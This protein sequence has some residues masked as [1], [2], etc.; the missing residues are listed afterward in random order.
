MAPPAAAQSPALCEQHK[1]HHT[2]QSL[3]SLTNLRRHWLEEPLRVFTITVPMTFLIRPGE[4]PA[5][6]VGSVLAYW[7]ILIHANVR[8]PLG[9]LAPVFCGPQ[10]HRTTTRASRRTGAGTSRP[11]FPVWDALFGNYWRPRPGEWTATGLTGSDERA[12]LADVVI[13]RSPAGP[14][15]RAPRRRAVVRRACPCSPTQ[16]VDQGLRITHWPTENAMLAMR[17][18][19][20]GRTPPLPVISPIATSSISCLRKPAMPAPWLGNSRAAG[21]GGG[22]A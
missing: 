10:H 17:G 15:L 8:L 14:L 4:V 3:N 6:L 21:S 16:N 1:L 20:A 7:S 22:A 9:P 11:S 18:S 2:E 5:T 12:S 13:A 19:R